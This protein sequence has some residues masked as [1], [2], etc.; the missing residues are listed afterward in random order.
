MDYEGEQAMELEALEAIFADHLEEFDSNKPE[1]W[2]KHGKTWAI[3]IHPSAGWYGVGVRAC[4]T[5]VCAYV[6][7]RVGSEG[8]RE[9]GG[10]VIGGGRMS[11]LG[12]THHQQ[13]TTRHHMAAAQNWQHCNACR[14]GEKDHF[15]HL[16]AAE[17]VSSAPSSFAWSSL[18]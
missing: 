16:P 9:G 8:G 2:S 12:H 7:G 5:G 4:V 1:G 11:T 17:A 10:A 3:T 15:A 14:E 18:H 6:C 13:Y